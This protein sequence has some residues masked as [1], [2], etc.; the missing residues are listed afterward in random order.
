M[1]EPSMLDKT[2]N[3]IMNRMVKSGLAPYY[4]DI[5]AELGLSMSVGKFH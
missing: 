2:F 1:S 4:S 5:A 3:I